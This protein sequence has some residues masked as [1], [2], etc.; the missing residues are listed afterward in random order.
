MFL[1]SRQR[2]PLCL[3]RTIFTPNRFM[4][5]LKG[6]MPSALLKIYIFIGHRNRLEFHI[7]CSE[8]YVAIHGAVMIFL[9]IYTYIFQP[10]I[11]VISLFGILS[12]P[13][14][15]FFRLTSNILV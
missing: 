9:E 15:N 10:L 3:N 4:L 13:V 6:V 5:G 7:P 8:M 11:S 14:I 1:V 2:L 12:L